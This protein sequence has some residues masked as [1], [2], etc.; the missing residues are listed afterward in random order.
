MGKP[1]T[2][3]WIYRARADSRAGSPDDV[4]REW[5]RQNRPCRAEHK[6]GQSRRLV[7]FLDGD[8]SSWGRADA[9]RVAGV[10]RLYDKRQAQRGRG[11]E[12][13][14]P[15]HQARGRLGI[16]FFDLCSGAGETA[17]ICVMRSSLRPHCFSGWEVPGPSLRGVE[18]WAGR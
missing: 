11:V 10:K 2:A 18:L 9:L 6:S 17:G 12:R 4:E 7:C 15:C 14:V 16:A 1:A 13:W 5:L 3:V 8:R